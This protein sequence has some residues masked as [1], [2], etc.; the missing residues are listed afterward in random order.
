[1]PAAIGSRGCSAGAVRIIGE[2][3]DE[4]RHGRWIARHAQQAFGIPLPLPVHRG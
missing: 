3:G 4:Y 2:V 1:M